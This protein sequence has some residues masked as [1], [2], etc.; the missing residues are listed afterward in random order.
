MTNF[1]QSCGK[2]TK[3]IT[4][5]L[6]IAFGLI[7]LLAVAALAF[8]AVILIEATSGKFLDLEYYEDASDD[9]ILD[10]TYHV[11]PLLGVVHP[12]EK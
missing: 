3:M 1:A 10:E 5:A 11:R 4:T 6:A 12:K 8:G 2:R 7:A 9:D